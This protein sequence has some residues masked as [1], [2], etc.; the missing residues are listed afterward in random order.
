VRAVLTDAPVEKV[1]N[2]VARTGLQ[3]QQ[4]Q[5]QYLQGA[6]QDRVLTGFT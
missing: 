4:Q 6:G 5:Q 3:Q 1:Y 2:M